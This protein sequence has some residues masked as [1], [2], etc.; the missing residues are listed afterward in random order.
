MCRDMCRKKE[1]EGGKSKQ[2]KA[3]SL[4]TCFSFHFLLPP[5]A[6]VHFPCYPALHITS[7][8]TF[9]LYSTI[10]SPSNLFFLDYSADGGQ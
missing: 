2:I 4:P 8:L 9:S 7:L 10:G 6:S 1:A 5:K 3:D